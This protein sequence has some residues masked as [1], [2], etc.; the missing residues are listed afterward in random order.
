MNAGLTIALA[1]ATA[2]VAEH[3]STAAI[4]TLGVT[5]GTWILNFIAA[6]HGGAWER[7]ADY[8]P[9]AM[10]AEFQHGLV[11]LDV[12]LTAVAF[13]AAG[14]VLAAI[15][16][17]IGTP[18][19]RRVHES[20]ALAAATAAVVF[21]CTFATASWDLS[22]SRGNSFSRADEAA[23]R[24]LDKPLRLE[25]HL[26]PEDPRRFDL[27]TR[28]ISKLRRTV[29]SLQVRYVSATSTG[30]FEQTSAHY[31]EIWYELAGRKMVSRT[32][33]VEGV[34]EAGEA[35]RWR[36]RRAA[37]PQS[38]TASG[39]RRWPPPH[40]SFAGARHEPNHRWCARR[41]NVSGDN[42]SDRAHR[43]FRSRRRPA[44]ASL[45]PSR[46]ALR[47]DL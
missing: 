25:V 21:A 4:L 42:R 9:T 20:A 40:L 18:I 31:G 1:A 43:S 11:R 35:I 38:F 27:E 14:L 8:T 45:P 13:A 47:R 29:P 2:S 23:L 36:C 10:V 24:Q 33:T 26:A 39:R 37:R 12:A 15:W 32:T 41:Q 28:A 3:P 34:L 5:V 6:V 19:R 30:L 16:M 7:A 46:G 22:E 17:R 44:F